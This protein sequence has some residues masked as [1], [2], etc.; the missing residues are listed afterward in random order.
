MSKRLQPSDLL[1]EVEGEERPKY[2]VKKVKVYDPHSPDF[3]PESV[4]ASVY[5]SEYCDKLIKLAA[6][7]Y[8]ARGFCAAVGVSWSSYMRWKKIPE[9][10]HAIEI[11][12]MKR[13]LFYEHQGVTNLKN[14]EFNSSLFEKLTKSIA[15][16]KDNEEV[17]HTHTHVLKK[18]E[19][20]TPLERQER[21]KELTNELG[22]SRD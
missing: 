14:R 16:W 1:F 3:D 13:H 11:A 15:R 5:K 17:T 7:G 19:E 21:I 4:H 20:M 2:P 8:S 22:R 18:P 12:N 10:A 9:F 6:A